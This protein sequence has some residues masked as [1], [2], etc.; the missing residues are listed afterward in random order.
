MGGRR[1]LEGA[2]PL[3]DEAAPVWGPLEFWA[4]YCGLRPVPPTFASTPAPLIG[5]RQ[6]AAQSSRWRRLL[7]GLI[8]KHQLDAATAA[9]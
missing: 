5:A 4:C 8:E 7:Q 6:A 1:K 9:A 3:W 2:T